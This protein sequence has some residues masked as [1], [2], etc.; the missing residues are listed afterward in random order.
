MKP[1]LKKT[2]T[3]FNFFDFSVYEKDNRKYAVVDEL[4]LNLLKGSKID[5]EEVMVRAGFVVKKIY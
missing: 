3:I 5:F 2:S 4:T 1:S